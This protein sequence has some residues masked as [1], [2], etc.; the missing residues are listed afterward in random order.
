MRG[1]CDE[2]MRHGGD[3]EGASTDLHVDVLMLEVRL[4]ALWSRERDYFRRRMADLLLV[5]A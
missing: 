4:S 1:V 2:L 3:Y 5:G